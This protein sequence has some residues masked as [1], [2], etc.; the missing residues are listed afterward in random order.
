MPSPTPVGDMETSK[1]LGL[2]DDY[3]YI[4]CFGDESSMGKRDMDL[5]TKRAF[6]GNKPRMCARRC[7]KE[8]GAT[9]FGLQNGDL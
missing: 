7:S 1:K 2:D 8:E 9:F 5:R 3:E 6:R 4:G